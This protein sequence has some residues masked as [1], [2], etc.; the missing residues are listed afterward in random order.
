VSDCF[1]GGDGLVEVFGGG[2][3]LAG[4]FGGGA[5]LAEV[6]GGGGGGAEVL[7]GGGF[8]VAGGASVDAFGFG[9]GRDGAGPIGAGR[10][11]T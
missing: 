10:R 4:V 7:G 8:E 3:G 9:V 6:F 11:K 1:G 5:G 2:A